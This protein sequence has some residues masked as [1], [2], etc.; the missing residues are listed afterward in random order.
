MRPSLQLVFELSWEYYLLD[1]EQYYKTEKTHHLSQLRISRKIKIKL[2]IHYYMLSRFTGHGGAERVRAP[3]LFVHCPA[4]TLSPFACMWGCTLT[5][6]WFPFAPLLWCAHPSACGGAP[7]PFCTPALVRPPIHSRAAPLPGLC[8]ASLACPLRTCEGTTVMV[9]VA[10]SFIPC[11]LSPCVRPSHLRA[12]PHPPAPL[13]CTQ[14][15]RV[16]GW[17]VVCKRG[18]DHG[19]VQVEGTG[20]GGA[21]ACPGR[22]GGGG[23]TLP[24]RPPAA[25]GGGGGGGGKGGVG[26]V[27][28][29]GWHGV[30]Q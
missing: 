17:G 28:Q 20:H 19:V 26:C 5:C 10:P 23:G 7:S 13:A 6:R 8:P 25:G 11:A 24:P 9:R 15:G 2:I 4:R 14:R 3:L 16:C 1:N 22:G 12:P 29:G 27:N 18:G 30:A 21:W